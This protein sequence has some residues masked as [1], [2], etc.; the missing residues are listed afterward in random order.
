MKSYLN[1]SEPEVAQ[2]A[3]L[4]KTKKY[5]IDKMAEDRALQMELLNHSFLLFLDEQNGKR[6][7]EFINVK[8][9]NYGIDEPEYDK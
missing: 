5:R 4:V 1:N 8:D 6:W 9:G 2:E 7:I 3:K